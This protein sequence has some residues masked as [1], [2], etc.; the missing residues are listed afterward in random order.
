MILF[1]NRILE[2]GD[3]SLEN[4]KLND[5]EWEQVGE[6]GV[7]LNGGYS[8]QLRFEC[9]SQYRFQLFLYTMCISMRSI[10]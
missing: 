4:I 5:F 7:V 2:S 6:S 8:E 3:H 9:V 1:S 10:S